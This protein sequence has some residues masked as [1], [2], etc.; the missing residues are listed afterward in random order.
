MEQKINSLFLSKITVSD[1]EIAYKEGRNA[2][3]I[4][5]ENISSFEVT[6][7][8][9]TIPGY[10]TII[11]KDGVVHQVHYASYHADA[12]KEIQEKR[13]YKN[14]QAPNN[15]EVI[16][17]KVSNNKKAS[18]SGKQ[19]RRYTSF[20]SG[21]NF[22][23]IDVTEKE[24]KYSNHGKNSIIEAMQV[25][26]IEVEKAGI[27]SLGKLNIT[28]S[29][30]NVCS[31]D[32][33]SKMNDVV[34]KWKKDF[35]DGTYKPQQKS[36]PK[37]MQYSQGSVRNSMMTKMEYL[38]E[39]VRIKTFSSD[40]ERNSI[41]CSYY[42]VK[43]IN[44]ETGR[45]KTNTVVHIQGADVYEVGI[46]SGL[47]EPYEVEELPETKPS[48]AQVVYAR[49]LGIVL[50]YDATADDASIFLTRAENQEAIHQKGASDELLKLI[51]L[52]Y[53]TYVPKYANCKE[54]YHRFY[55]ALSKT[56]QIAYFI[57]RVVAEAKGL[58][59]LFPCD[60][61]DE[62]W[63]AY[64]NIAKEKQADNKFMESFWYYSA[65]DFP[66]RGKIQK[67]LKAYRDIVNIKDI[68]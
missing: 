56:E 13:G 44:P 38:T 21:E 5:W 16:E 17:A 36:S 29:D 4:A 64:L 7:G 20:G 30:G 67:Q 33:V 40:K 27:F 8:T 10:I 6:V 19:Y 41:I 11:E 25:V 2:G 54:A 60:V 3:K 28:T 51:I 66:M 53:G 68:L 62:E 50:P 46:K 49:D 1:L 22:I 37:Q 43:G 59:Y 15:V 9:I 42:K 47:L 18:N 39:K 26:K 52:K 32:I 35:D 55:Y 61:A 31:I 12:I 63:D 14:I 65:T 34:M 58:I 24:I 23:E 57:M 45:R 48:D